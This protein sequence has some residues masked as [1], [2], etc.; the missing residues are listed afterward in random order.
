[1]GELPRPFVTWSQLGVGGQAKGEERK[2][3]QGEDGGG[4]A[5][6]LG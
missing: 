3:E 2:R 4:W 5:V 6:R 1:M